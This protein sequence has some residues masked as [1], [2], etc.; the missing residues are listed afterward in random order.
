M[1]AMSGGRSTF[2]KS[3]S[4]CA[5]TVGSS[6][7]LTSNICRGEVISEHSAGAGLAIRAGSDIL[8]S[9]TG[10]CETSN[11]AKVCFQL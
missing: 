8:A 4:F 6:S 11:I 7:A 9:Q 1:L 10:D 3:R 5:Q 2:Q